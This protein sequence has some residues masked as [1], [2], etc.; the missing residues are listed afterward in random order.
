MTTLAFRGPTSDQAGEKQWVDS[1]LTNMSATEKIG[2]LFMVAAYSNK[3]QAYEDHLVQ[4]METYHLGGFIFMQGTP[5]RQRIMINRLQAASKIPLMIG[6]DAEWG[7]SMRMDGTPSF[8]KNMTLGAIRDDS[9]LFLLGKELAWQLKAVGAN[10]NFAPVLD[11]NNNPQNPIIGNRSFGDNPY[12]VARQG[13]MLSKGL[14]A[15]GVMPVAKH[16]PGHG[17]TDKDSHHSLPILPYSAER[18]DSIE[19]YPFRKA[20]TAGIAGMMVGHLQVPVLDKKAKQPASLSPVLVSDILRKKM[21]YEGLVFTDALNM[22]GVTLSAPGKGMP[23]LKAFLAG[24]DVLLF[25]EDLGS[26]AKRILAA[27]KSGQISEKQLNTRVRRIL[28]AKYRL[29]LNRAPSSLVNQTLERPQA[30]II[31]KKLHEAAIT[32]VRNDSLLVAVRSLDQRFALLNANGGLPTFTEKLKTYAAVRAYSLPGSMS[33]AQTNAVAAQLKNYP[34]VIV[35]IPGS[36]R[37]SKRYGIPLSLAATVQALRG[38]GQRVVL[39]YFGSPYGLAQLPESEAILLG[40]ERSQEAQSAMAMAIFG[41]RDVNGRLPVRVSAQYPE[42]AG[43][44][45]RSLGRYGF[46]LPEEEGMDRRIL[47]RID[48]LAKYY[49]QRGAMPGCAVLVGRGNNIVYAK[50]FGH[51]EVGGKPIDPYLHTYDLASVTKVMATTVCAMKLTEEGLLSLDKPISRYIPDLKGTNKSRLTARRLLQ[52]NAGLPAWRPF[53]RLTYSD[54]PEKKIPDPRYYSKIKKDSFSITISPNLH[55]TPTLHDTLWTW[56]KD[57][58]VEQTTRVRYSDIGLLLTQKVVESI[59]GGSSLDRLAYMYFY[60]DMG[61]VSTGFK[62]GERG[63]ESRCP[64][65]AVDDYWR[66]EK[67]KGYVH[68]ECSAIFG[69]VAGHAGL[70]SNSYD[71]AKMLFMLKNEGYYGGQQ[72]LRPETIKAFTK[73]QLA[74][75]R[76]ALGW[77]RPESSPYK[78]NPAS[79]FSSS[80][81]F[82]HTGFTG[83]CV[84]VDPEHDLV[85]IFLSNRTYPNPRNKMLNREHVRSKIF[86]QVYEAISSFEKRNI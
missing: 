6:M 44:S 18:L 20:A 74:N 69:G 39:A 30:Q 35:S 75:N 21:G 51:T 59:S 80:Q 79:K 43:I 34:T 1:M 31:R 54:P 3:S 19:L 53:F 68:D 45:T 42:G 50:G 40:Y 37:K 71:L 5:Q 36:Y 86:D 62:P 47:K 85:F 57:M 10:V 33:P 13:I 8:P 55:I 52:H 12:R 56:I 64:P 66:R 4:M 48:S 11:V 2:Q 29:G 73:K 15:G 63:L 84:W 17:D 49:I 41:G 77:D 26:A 83:T 32:L 81:T 58:E 82:G 72:F 70:F 78:S 7:L 25:P 23:S 16:Y 61:M 76:K 22:K 14:S 65:S 46:G 24:N 28:T 67:L 27:L 38:Q 9:L 60:R